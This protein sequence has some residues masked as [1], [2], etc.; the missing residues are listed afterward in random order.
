MIS[1]FRFYICSVLMINDRRWASFE[2]L[3]IPKNTVN[4]LP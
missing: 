4:Y 3:R 1:N 2:L